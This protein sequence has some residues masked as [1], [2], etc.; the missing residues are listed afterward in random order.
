MLK[1]FGELV[2]QLVKKPP[3]AKEPAIPYRIHKSPALVRIRYQSNPV[4]ILKR[5]CLT[6]ILNG[7]C[8]LLNKTLPFQQ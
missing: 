5:I 3:H 2:P 6:Y 4:D 7:S 1:R 8:L